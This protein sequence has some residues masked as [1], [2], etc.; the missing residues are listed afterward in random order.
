MAEFPVT[1]EAAGLDVQETFLQQPFFLGFSL[2]AP[3]WSLCFIREVSL[4]QILEDK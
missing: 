1:Q 4:M 3:V 2:S